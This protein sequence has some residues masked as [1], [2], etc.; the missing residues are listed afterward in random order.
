MLGSVAQVERHSDAGRILFFVV[1]DKGREKEMKINPLGCL[2]LSP[3]FSTFSDLFTCFVR[4]VLFAISCSS[5]HHGHLDK[6][7]SSPPPPLPPRSP[8]ATTPVTTAAVATQ[9]CQ[10]R[11]R[12]LFPAVCFPPNKRN[13]AFLSSLTL[14]VGRRELWR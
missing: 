7:S 11:H 1:E 6:L 2:F 3:L 5:F 12:R 8:V 14:V 10:T 4:T 9:I 13:W